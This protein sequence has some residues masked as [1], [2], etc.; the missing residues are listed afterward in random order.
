[1]MNKL[2]VMNHKQY[3]VING[4][5][6]NVLTFNCGALNFRSLTFLI[7]IN[8]LH[9]AIKYCEVHQIA[10]VTNLLNLNNSN[11]QV[12]HDLKNYQIG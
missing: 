10:D 11:K 3:V 4:F 8:G 7:Y 12:S 5:N 6:S 2:F 9:C 1:M